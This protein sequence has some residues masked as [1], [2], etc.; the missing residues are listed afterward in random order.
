MPGF[1]FA[2]ASQGGVNGSYRKTAELKNGMPVYKKVGSAVCCWVGGSCTWLL[3]SSA[4]KTANKNEGMAVSTGVGFPTPQ[5]ESAW[6]VAANGKFAAEQRVKITSDF[7]TAG[8]TLANATAA[9]ANGT[10]IKTWAEQQNGAPVYFKLDDQTKRCWYGTNKKWIVGDVADQQSNKCTGFAMAVHAGSPAPEDV[11]G[12][13]IA[14]NAKWDQQVRV[15]MAV[16]SR[17]QI[18]NVTLGNGN[19]LV[20]MGVPQTKL[21]T[22]CLHPF[23]VG[24][25]IQNSATKPSVQIS[26]PECP[27]PGVNIDKRR[28][29]ATFPDQVAAGPSWLLLAMPVAFKGETHVGS[30]ETSGLKLYEGAI[31]FIL[32]PDV[33]DVRKM[34]CWFP[35]FE[36]GI[37]CPLSRVRTLK[38]SEKMKLDG[39][40]K[41]VET[42]YCDQTAAMIAGTAAK[43]ADNRFSSVIST[44]SVRHSERAANLAAGAGAFTQQE[45]HVQRSNNERAGRGRITDTQVEAE[46]R[47]NQAVGKGKITHAEVSV[48]QTDNYESGLGLYTDVEIKAQYAANASAGLGEITDLQ[49]SEQRTANETAGK[50]NYT[51]AE[52]AKQRQNNSAAGIGSV[53]NAT[54]AIFQRQVKANSRA[55]L[56]ALTTAD[57]T[58]LAVE[59]ATTNVLAEKQA[60][61]VADEAKRTA[62][63]AR[64]GSGFHYGGGVLD[65]AI[66]PWIVQ[67]FQHVESTPSY[68]ALKAAWFA[69][70]E[71]HAEYSTAGVLFGD[72][73]WNA[74]KSRIQDM[75][76]LRENVTPSKHELASD[77][78]VGLLDDAVVKGRDDTAQIVSGGDV[79]SQ[80]APT[81]TRVEPAAPIISGNKLPADTMPELPPITY[82]NDEGNPV[83]LGDNTTHPGYDGSGTY[84]C[85]QHRDILYSDGECGPKAGNPC[86]SCVRFQQGLADR[87]AKPL[88]VEPAVAIPVVQA[89]KS[90]RSNSMASKL[91]FE[92]SLPQRESAFPEM[93]PPGEIPTFPLPPEHVVNSC[94][95]CMTPACDRIFT[96]FLRRKSCG[97]CH[98]TVCKHCLI[99]D[100]LT[101]VISESER[102][103]SMFLASRKMLVCLSC[104]KMINDRFEIDRQEEA[105]WAHKE[106]TAQVTEA[107]KVQLKCDGAEAS[108]AQE[109][110][111]IV[112]QEAE[113]AAAEALQQEKRRKERDARQAI[114]DA[115]A[116]AR[117]EFEE[118]KAAETKR[119]KDEQD[120]LEAKRHKEE[121]DAAEA[122]AKEAARIA[123]AKQA[124]KDALEE[125][126]HKK[127][128]IVRSAHVASE[129]ADML[130]N[131]NACCKFQIPAQLEHAMDYADK[132]EAKLQRSN[133]SL[134][135]ALA[136]MKGSA[137]TGGSRPELLETDLDKLARRDRFRLQYV[138]AGVALIDA[139]KQEDTVVR[140]KNANWTSS[141]TES[142]LIHMIARLDKD[143]RASRPW[144]TD[145]E[146]VV[147]SEFVTTLQEWAA[148]ANKRADKAADMHAKRMAAAH[149][150]RLA[151]EADQVAAP[152][153]GHDGSVAITD[154][155]SDTS[156]AGGADDSLDGSL[157]D[158]PAGKIDASTTDG[159]NDTPT[160]LFGVA[161]GSA[162][163]GG[164][165]NDDANDSQDDLFAPAKA[166]SRA[167]KIKKKT[168]LLF[169]SDESEVNKDFLL[170]SPRPS[171]TVA[172]SNPIATQSMESVGPD[173][174]TRVAYMYAEVR[175]YLTDAVTELRIRVA[176]VSTRTNA[177]ELKMIRTRLALASVRIAALGGGSATRGGRANPNEKMVMHADDGQRIID[178]P[179][180][181]KATVPPLD[182][183]D[184][185]LCTVDVAPVPS[186]GVSKTT[187]NTGTGTVSL[188]SANEM[189]PSFTTVEIQSAMN[190]TYQALRRVFQPN[191]LY[192]GKVVMGHV[193]DQIKLQTLELMQRTTDADPNTSHKQISA[194]V[195]SVNF[196][197]DEVKG[198]MNGT[199]QAVRQ[200][201]E[202]EA[203]F[204][205]KSALNH[206]LHAIKDTTME[207]IQHAADDAEDK[208]N[209]DDSNEED[210]EPAPV[211][212]AIGDGQLVNGLDPL[213]L[214]ACPHCTFWND[215]RLE[216]CTICNLSLTVL[217]S[218]LAQMDKHDEDAA[219]APAKAKAKAKEP[220]PEPEEEEE[221]EAKAP[222]KKKPA[223]A[224]GMPGMGGAALFGGG[225]PGLKKKGA[226]GAK[227]NAF[228]DDDDSSEDEAPAPEPAP[229][230]KVEAKKVPAKKAGGMFDD[231]EDDDDMFGDSAP[232]AKA[233]PAK[234]ST[235]AKKKGGMFDD[236]DEDEDMFA[237]APAPK[238]KAKASEPAPAVDLADVVV[239]SP[240]TLNVAQK[241]RASV[242]KGTRRLPSRKGRGG[243]GGAAPAPAAA[244]P[245]TA[246]IAEAED[247]SDDDM[248]ASAPPSKTKA[249]TPE[250]EPVSA[251]AAEEDEEDEEEEEEEVPAPAPVKKAPKLVTQTD[252]DIFAQGKPKKG[253]GSPAPDDDV[254]IFADIAPPT[255]KTKAKKKTSK[256]KPAAVTGDADI[257]AEAPAATTKAKAA[258]K[259]K[260]SKAKKKKGPAAK[261]TDIFGDDD[262]DIFA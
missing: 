112:Q 185:L 257:F 70:N 4:N 202:P 154:N 58:S 39:L 75:L 123:A 121:R 175:G 240:A 84:Y 237:S 57:L 91:I 231:D 125:L 8:F 110:K 207:L 178:H 54:L 197:I 1:T 260:K 163:D 7:Y 99:G 10:F 137:L 156:I 225:A 61:A 37:T 205:G 193:L 66:M 167:K 23:S 243:G 136:K 226:G 130:L 224:V 28:L 214:L 238:A 25:V 114:I 249:K 3:G 228:F 48:M 60:Q 89:S 118:L 187:A 85:G 242:A 94:N 169:L 33:S 135:K 35:K 168:N 134:R 21:T 143:P 92:P 173:A 204:V 236:D 195:T 80:A 93:F 86:A 227:K 213:A 186:D 241:T 245:K 200:V 170:F 22:G 65:L 97:L 18:Q 96:L 206:I 199:F 142:S 74:N 209:I 31:G 150:K 253:K 221:E 126:A 179:E 106:A 127:M 250:P 115:R 229:T 76:Y 212:A 73:V 13:Q 72:Y 145:A 171:S 116:K 34:T 210:T 107:R 141:W 17:D 42:L 254:D 46:Q 234:K 198:A 147:L 102:R 20:Y 152:D 252:D 230:K 67:Y 63:L 233:A 62:W 211:A 201:L 247:D 64:W 69:W 32:G 158:V 113:V 259:E 124:R 177:A 183:P 78:G 239:D 181:G 165:D 59:A 208:G 129:A 251:P 133:A 47:A 246:V 100:D 81:L 190:A 182:L 155:I 192:K 149:V 9:E 184:E 218:L 27:S 194:S 176:E 131:Q 220:E 189:A 219:P 77:L 196:T 49:V 87:S 26:F 140:I 232:K 180:A 71:T 51:D 215:P 43:L 55:K 53:S 128:A 95:E 79:G 235:P 117:Q 139:M 108:L 162:V 159:I 19:T 30:G 52:V 144:G 36:S 90:V 255:A 101:Q 29:S 56:G 16:L 12:W 191:E 160:S 222:V 45:V 83:A 68:T 105:G 166:A 6:K 103:T 223:G 138:E 109:E 217:D 153:E 24:K 151:M 146:A 132:W 15:R 157:S 14:K 262:D 11:S 120:A 216:Q 161:I 111:F 148:G 261:S 88:S 258:P 82:V 174:T 122:V 203:T 188:T 40:L 41:K 164:F 5:L 244:E 98:A 119:Q 104:A 2:G 248:F 256:K 38:A 172:S 44:A 50:G